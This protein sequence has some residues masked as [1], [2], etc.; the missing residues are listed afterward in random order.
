LA[1]DRVQRQAVVFDHTLQFPPDPDPE[2][3]GHVETT[4]PGGLRFTLDTEESIL[5][6]DPDWLPP[7]GGHRMAVAFLCESP[8]EVDCVYR[9]LI[10]AALRVTEN[11]GMH[12]GASATPRRRIPT[13]TTSSSSRHSN[14]DSCPAIRGTI[15]LGT[16]QLAHEPPGFATG[17]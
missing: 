9:E 16:S 10:E 5:S 12:A 15:R 17:P 8:P 4:L 14:A 6:F 1:N 2:S 7:A 13:A 11:P 3:H